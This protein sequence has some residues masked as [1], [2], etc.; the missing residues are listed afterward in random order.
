MKRNPF[1]V[2]K[3]FI[4]V[5]NLALVM[6]GLTFVDRAMHQEVDQIQASE[7]PSEAIL[8]YAYTEKGKVD[9]FF[10]EMELDVSKI[11]AAHVRTSLG[12]WR[13]YITHYADMYGV[14]EDLVSAI[15]YAESK[16]NPSS[17]SHVG[18]LGLMQIMPSTASFLG[19]DNVM[20]PEKNIKA[21]VKYIARLLRQYDEGRALWAWNAGPVR[22]ERKQLPGE[23]RK[24][25]VEVLSV[26]SLLKDNRLQQQSM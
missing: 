13:P 7:P 12:P 4:G 20:D 19:F 17:I 11:K 1:F 5:G 8:P 6:A 10:D 18:A 21:G 23:T 16:G 9:R 26:K 2:H 24:F 3:L 14:D 15:V 22:V 25:I